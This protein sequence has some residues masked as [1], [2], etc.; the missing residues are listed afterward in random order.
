MYFCI[1]TILYIL[2]ILYTMY[3]RKKTL[4][5]IILLFCHIIPQAPQQFYP[6]NLPTLLYS[7]GFTDWWE[8]RTSLV[9]MHV[10]KRTA[11]CHR[12]SKGKIKR[13]SQLKT[14][15][16]WRCLCVDLCS[17]CFRTYPTV[18]CF[19]FVIKGAWYFFPFKI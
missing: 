3:A 2:F 18:F 7:V 19:Y 14:V 13:D 10:C 1:Y 4:T 12:N 9:G 17:A 11:N 8:I 6:L 5:W 15:K 16:C